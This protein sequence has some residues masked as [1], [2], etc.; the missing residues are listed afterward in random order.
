M[1]I[2]YEQNRTDYE[3]KVN[4]LWIKYERKWILMWFRVN[5][6]D[7]EWKFDENNRHK[8]AEVSKST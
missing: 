6:N 2:N 1:W 8:V 5:L 3:Q 7:F 4:K